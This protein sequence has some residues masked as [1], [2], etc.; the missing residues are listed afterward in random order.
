M[1]DSRAW[2]S[3]SWVGLRDL[4]QLSFNM[5]SWLFS[6]PALSPDSQIGGLCM[7]PLVSKLPLA[8]C[9]GTHRLHLNIWGLPWWLSGKESASQCRRPGFDPRS[10]KIPHP[11]EQW[12]PCTTTT[13]PVLW[14]LRAELLKPQ[15]L[16][17]TG[18][19]ARLCIKR[20][21]RDENPMLR[22]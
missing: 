8:V 18:P 9:A 2:V 21:R 16:K 10:G 22:N 5:Q 12:S 1:S 11:E 4:T 17:P 6:H 13:K 7:R 19:R 3:K 20:S 15:L 14:S